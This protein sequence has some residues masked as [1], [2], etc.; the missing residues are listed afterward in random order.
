MTVFYRIQIPH[1]K[2]SENSG[3]QKFSEPLENVS[4]TLKSSQKSLGEKGSS[5]RDFFEN[6][7]FADERSDPVINSE[8]ASGKYLLVLLH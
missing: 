3:P 6:F 1:S 4:K 5:H 2:V 7:S 8:T